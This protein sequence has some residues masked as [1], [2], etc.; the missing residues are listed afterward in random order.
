MAGVKLIISEIQKVEIKDNE[1]N[2]KG[3]M[4]IK[5]VM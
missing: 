1:M 4:A 5:K 2:Q 3:D